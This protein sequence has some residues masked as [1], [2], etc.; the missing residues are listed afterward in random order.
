LVNKSEKLSIR[1]LFKKMKRFFSPIHLQRSCRGFSLVESVL[2]L[3][4]M[5]CG[6]LALA[7]LLTLGLNSAQVARGDR[8]MAQIAETM[9]E[10]AKQG[11]L[12]AGTFYLDSESNPCPAAQAAYIA[13]GSLADFSA[14]G[15][16][17][18]PL[19]QLTVRVTPRALPHT[20]RIYADVFPT[21]AP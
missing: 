13:Q 21:P 1:H 2:A 4:I 7:P 8:M 12:T 17:G 10:Q 16:T 6:V 18:A 15:S 5:S 11:T 9:I 20:V 14:D 19:T 3:G